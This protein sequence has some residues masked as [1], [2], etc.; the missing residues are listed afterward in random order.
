MAIPDLKPPVTAETI[1]ESVRNAKRIL[2]H[3]VQDLEDLRDSAALQVR[4]APLTTVGIALGTGLLLGLALGW[5]S[6]RV[7][8]GCQEKSAA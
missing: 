2:K 5:M 7:S 6:T 8:A 3:R 4:K 1:E